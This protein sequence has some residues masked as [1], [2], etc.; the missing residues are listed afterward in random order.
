MMRRIGIAGTVLVIAVAAGCSP[1][2]VAKRAFYEA[3]G[4]TGNVLVRG[5][6]PDVATMESVRL[7]E[8][9]NTAM[10]LTPSEF[11]AVLKSSL[12]SE[13]RTAGVAVN[14]EA[15]VT[16]EMDIVYYEDPN[17]LTGAISPFHL[18]VVHVTLM[19]T[20]GKDLGKLT[21]VGESK[22][23][24]TDPAEVAKVMARELAKYLAGGRQEDGKKEAGKKEASKPADSAQDDSKPEEGT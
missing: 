13:L 12:L 24:R 22:A 20:E 5:T 19:G 17:A 3:R 15:P 21:V 11:L 1:T 18:G 7:G 9:Q 8:I 6:A 2:S 23:S 16:I 4:A 14:A 10:T